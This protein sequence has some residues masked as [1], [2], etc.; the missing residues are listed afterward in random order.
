MPDEVIDEQSIKNRKLN[1][2][3][4]CFDYAYIKK[5]Q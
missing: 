1:I 3:Y 4:R 2:A 5:I